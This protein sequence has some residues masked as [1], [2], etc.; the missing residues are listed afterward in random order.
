MNINVKIERAIVTALVDEA[1]KVGYIPDSVWDGGEYV[2]V[3]DLNS[4]LEAVFAV[5]N[6]TIHF[7]PRAGPESASSHGVFVVCGRS[8]PFLQTFY[9]NSYERR[10][11]STSTRR[12]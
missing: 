4:V 8:M 1:A 11:R 7:V 2:P 12:R 9:L 6:S 3:A 10:S 5:D